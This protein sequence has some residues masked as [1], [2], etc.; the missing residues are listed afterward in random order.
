MNIDAK[1]WASRLIED[2]N[3]VLLD[4]RSPEEYN[5]G[6]FPDAI[7]VD[8]FQAKKFFDY[9]RK[10]DPSKNYYV[11]CQTGGRGSQACSVMNELGIN[12]AFNLADGYE[13]W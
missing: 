9:V 4:V 10:M 6:H 7:N 2:A 11:Y 3:A 12:N 8:I 13:K 1:E 5:K